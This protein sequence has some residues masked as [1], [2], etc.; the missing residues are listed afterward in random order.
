MDTAASDDEIIARVLS[1][2]LDAY[3]VLFDRYKRY[4]ARILG[5]YLT[6]QEV[7][8]ALIEV[9]TR[10]HRKLSSYDSRAPFRYWISTIAVRRS[11][12]ILRERKE[13]RE[14]MSQ[15]LDD[16]HTEWMDQVLHGESRAQFDAEE[17]KRLAANVLT[18]ALAQ[19]GP[20][21]RMVLTLVHFE[22][23]SYR[24]AAEILGWSEVNVRVRALRARK[25]LKEILTK[26]RNV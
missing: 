6:P 22:E 5:K 16:T 10:A 21:Q 11:Y 2:E 23:R 4:V 25:A 15:T 18:W 14:V 17:E 12:D 20:E 26:G 3:A 13:R 24:E 8:D 9:F 19:L 1:G 7:E